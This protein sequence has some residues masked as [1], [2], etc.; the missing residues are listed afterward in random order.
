MAQQNINIGALGAGNGDT[1][2][3]AA[4]KI[5]NNFTDLY[6]QFPHA[7]F[8]HTGSFFITGSSGYAATL[9]VTGSISLN[10]RGQNTP[11]TS[12][13]LVIR[14][15]AGRSPGEENP[16]ILSSS[17][18]QIPFQTFIA[19]RRDDDLDTSLQ[20]Y[21]SINFITSTTQLTNFDSNL[22]LRFQKYK[23]P[24]LPAFDSR[25]SSLYKS[26]T[27]KND[28]GGIAFQVSASASP[29]EVSVGINRAAPLFVRSV[30]LDG[31]VSAS[32]FKF[33]TDTGDFVNGTDPGE[34]TQ[35]YLADAGDIFGDDKSLG[36]K[37]LCISQGPKPLPRRGLVYM[38][39]SGLTGSHANGVTTIFESP[40]PIVSPVLSTFKS[41]IRSKAGFT[42]GQNLGF[43]NE[44]YSTDS[45]YPGLKFQIYDTNASYSSM[46]ISEDQGFPSDSAR[47]SSSFVF[48]WKGVTDEPYT[49]P[50]AWR[51]F[52]GSRRNNNNSSLALG[53]RDSV[54]G[55]D[56]LVVLT[57]TNAMV[58]MSNYFGSE[59]VDDWHMVALCFE[60]SSGVDKKFKTFFKTNVSESFIDDNITI[61][62]WNT[63]TKNV[64]IGDD[65]GAGSGAKFTSSLFMY[66]TSSL[67]YN[68]L[69]DTYNYFS[70][71]HG[72]TP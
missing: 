33:A 71:S 51:K 38:W 59:G 34:A 24:I 15:D 3:Q 35:F 27:V 70:G 41:A 5:E 37:V 8:P 61:S 14:P 55:T 52:M 42:D 29:P 44:D 17:I 46:S 28:A 47:V 39:A 62:Q 1:L 68:E 30:Y 72:L 36:Q 25:E 53:R 19:Y 60:G 45:N 66:Y 40:R 57:G 31:A 7:I 20:G 21:T 49:T 43:G 13:Q 10:S 58:T 63:P 50:Q 54:Y 26:V 12:S 23:H 4:I 67:T 16:S 18:C 22:A 69:I 64:F 48:W 6:P 9:G 11:I 65:L 56:N 2:R 32:Q